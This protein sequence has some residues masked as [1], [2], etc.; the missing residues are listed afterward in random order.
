MKILGLNP[1]DFYAGWPVQSDFG[2]ELYRSPALTFPVLRRLTP[3]EHEMRFLEGFFEPITMREYMEWVKWPDVVGFNIASSYG[4]ISYAVAIAQVKRLNPKATIVAGGH[5]AN[6]FARRWLDLGVDIV[7]KGEAERSWPVLVGELAGGRRFDRVPGVVFKQDGEVVETENAPLLENLDDSPMPDLSLI[8]FEIYP[9]LIDD[10]GGHIGSIETSRGCVFRCK[11]CAVPGYWKGSQRYKSTGR[12]MEEIKRLEE[13]RCHQINIL[14]DGFGNDPDRLEDLLAAMRNHP[15]RLNL[16]GFLRVDTVLKDPSL[17]E[18]LAAAGMRAA[19]LGFE[20]VNEEV[21][22]KQFGKG[23]RVPPTL[24]DLQA[25]YQRFKKNKIMVIGVFISGH[26]EIQPEQE[27]PYAVARTVCDDPRLADYMPWPGSL[28]YPEL[29]EKYPVKDM[30]F[31]E[32]KLPV[33]PWHNVEA[34][35]FNLMNVI[36]APRTLRMLAGP[37]QYR[38]YLLWSHRMLWPKFFRINRTKLRDFWLLRN[39]RKSAN[40]RQEQLMKLYLQNPEYER[41]LDRQTDRV[42]F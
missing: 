8:N 13:Y 9:C 29:A 1:K 19:L 17:I 26:P 23:M 15:R 18:R 16:N 33:F 20:S 7:V 37:V 10:R 31:H 35:R 6:V 34:F 24:A 28:G 4:A 41:W 27:T 2:R 11:F 36:D 25:M 42:W 12:V 22:K 5:H 14:D 21:L 38:M 40:A 32:V 30:F 39:R 3:P